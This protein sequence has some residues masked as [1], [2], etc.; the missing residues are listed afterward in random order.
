MKVASIARLRMGSSS[1]IRDTSAQDVAIDP[2]PARKRRLRILIASGVGALLLIA[3]AVPAFLR[4]FDA[5]I[6]VPRERVRIA[7]VTRGPFVRD[8]SA[9]GVV[10][11]AVSPTL[12]SPAGGYVTYN[13]QA[14]DTV[15]K[16]Q[17]LGTVSSPQLENELAR[18]QA[19]AESLEVAVARQAIETR[20]ELLANQQ[21]TDNAE[22][23]IHAAERELKRAE[24]AWQSR[25]IS[26]RDYEK[27]RDD[28]T[29]AKLAHEHAIENASLEK[30]SLEFELKTRRLERDRQ[31]LLVQDLKR[32]V[33]ELTLRSPVDGVV[34]TLAVNQKAAVAANAALISVVDLSAFEIEFQ[35]PE[36][37]ADDI[38][39]GMQ[40]DVTY[41]QKNYA[42]TV[43]AISPEVKQNQVT[44][45]LRFAGEV[46]PG[47]RQNQRVSTRIVLE[48][49]ADALTVQRGSF[50]DSGGGRVA[51]VVQD[52]LARRTPIKISASSIG[53]IEI[54]SG[55]NEG[56]EIII[57]GT[58][59]FG[60][61]EIVRL[62]D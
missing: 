1:G 11:A 12:F 59:T 41:G 13:V 53:A 4:W 16:G 24:D 49:H 32:R 22:V 26:Q 47:L 48:S 34:G 61:A 20:K 58:D 60:D 6:S 8:T 28:L 7:T 42:A 37:Y 57:S 40:A 62:T 54:A 18:E 36:S 21:T 29:T 44:G 56:D 51:Y 9:Q 45:R 23:S 33:D 15:K 43:T 27:A 55:L 35:V 39:L 50:I 5:E 52:G 10:V 25:A 3:I 17:V 30:E 19:T 46:P 2:A 31:K 38:G 14:G